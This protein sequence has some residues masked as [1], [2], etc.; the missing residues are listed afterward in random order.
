LE[1]QTESGID[2]IKT[3]SAA[4]RSI[5]RRDEVAV[6]VSQTTVPLAMATPLVVVS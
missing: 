3:K 2:R 5:S 1:L 6:A 4:N